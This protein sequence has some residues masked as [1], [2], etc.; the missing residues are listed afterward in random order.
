LP[1]SFMTS[2]STCFAVK[3]IPFS[4]IK[5]PVPIKLINPCLLCLIIGKMVCDGSTILPLPSIAPYVPVGTAPF[6]FFGFSFES[7]SG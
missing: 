6:K 4:A 2:I 5:N 7:P 1:F 3:K